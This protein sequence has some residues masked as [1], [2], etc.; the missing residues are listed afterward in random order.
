MNSKRIEKI[1]TRFDGVDNVTD[2][3]VIKIKGGLKSTQNHNL[4]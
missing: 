3:E 1:L 2:T 4:K